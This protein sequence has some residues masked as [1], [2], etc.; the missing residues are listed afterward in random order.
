MS[1]PLPEYGGCRVCADPA[2]RR[3][4]CAR[5]YMRLR[6]HGDP[7]AGQRDRPKNWVELVALSDH[8]LIWIGGI[9]EG[10]YGRYNDQYAH[11]L[12]YEHF[13]GPIPEG[14]V[15]D[16]LPECP[17]T[18]VTPEHLTPMT[19]SDHNRLGWERGEITSRW[20]MAHV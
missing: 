9:K 14:L 6:R 8:G 16:H 13:V 4:L 2:Y 17:K 10:P 1:E 11:R 20:E 19:Q 5:H 15:L 18:C 7:L 12:S 3:D